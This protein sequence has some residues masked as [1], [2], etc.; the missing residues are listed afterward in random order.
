MSFTV[1]NVTNGRF[2]YVSTPGMGIT[3]F[4][5]AEVAGGLVRFVHDGSG[6]APAYEVTV[7]DGVLGDGPRAASITFNPT[8]PRRWSLPPPPMPVPHRAAAS[9]RAAA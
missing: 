5:Q 8:P 4:T 3:T 9:R 7:S 1:T 6:S 2:E